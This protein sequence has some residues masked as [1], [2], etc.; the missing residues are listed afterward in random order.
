MREKFIELISLTTLLF[1]LLRGIEIVKF[2][3][4]PELERPVLIL[5][6]LSSFIFEMSRIFMKILCCKKF[7]RIESNFLFLT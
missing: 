3:E 5:I 7:V 4:L 1:N 6:G 2:Q